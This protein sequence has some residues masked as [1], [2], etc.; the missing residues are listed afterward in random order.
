MLILSPGSLRRR[1]QIR[2]FAWDE[3]VSEAIVEKPEWATIW[4]CFAGSQRCGEEFRKRSNCSRHVPQ[5]DL[6][7]HLLFQEMISWLLQEIHFYL[8]LL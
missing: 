7:F 1:Q 8:L 2:H 4:D 5:L 3:S 6:P